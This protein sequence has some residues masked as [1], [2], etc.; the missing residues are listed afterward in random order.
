MADEIYRVPREAGESGETGQSGKSGS[1]LNFAPDL[2]SALRPASDAE[3]EPDTDVWAV[4]TGRISVSPLL[5]TFA[6]PHLPT[7]QLSVLNL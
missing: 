4:C 6:Q 1:Y 5:T 3:L 7:T 2:S